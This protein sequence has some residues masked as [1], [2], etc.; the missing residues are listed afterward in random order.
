MKVIFYQSEKK[1]SEKFT[2]LGDVSVSINDGAVILRGIEL[3][4]TDKKKWLKM[5]S[6]KYTKNGETC[7]FNF[8]A[9]NKDFLNAILT[10]A[11]KQI[12]T[13]DLPL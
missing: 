7:Y 11:I 4:E 1:V 5:P 9:L 8:I 10:E 6:R 12:K 2:K 3:C 13:E